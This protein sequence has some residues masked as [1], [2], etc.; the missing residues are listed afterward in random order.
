LVEAGIKLN[1]PLDKTTRA[2][3]IGNVY[4]ESNKPS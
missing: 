3:K 4:T 2:R 1:V